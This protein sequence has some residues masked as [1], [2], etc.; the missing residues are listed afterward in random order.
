MQD[1]VA[2]EA[3]IIV[4]DVLQY[5]KGWKDL[6]LSLTENIQSLEV[7][8]N[9]DGSY[10]YFKNTEDFN[11]SKNGQ[12]VEVSKEAIPK[13]ISKEQQQ[14]WL[15]AGY[16]KVILIRTKQQP[17]SDKTLV[18]VDGVPQYGK[19]LDEV[20][21]ELRESPLYD[22]FSL[23]S[24]GAD[25][26]QAILRVL[27]AEGYDKVVRID[28][29]ASKKKGGKFD[30]AHLGRLLQVFPNPTQDW[31]NLQ[32]TI[33]EALPITVTVLDSQGQPLTTLADKTYPAGSHE[34][35]W[36]ASDQKPGVYFIQWTVGEQRVTRK[37]V[38]E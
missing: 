11:A 28:S 29:W 34:V 1:S 32:F 6:N 9:R 16:E 23:T 2:E 38:I 22:H 20:D 14:E 31:F 3:L 15:A 4:D 24:H 7:L 21:Q 36:D 12:G 27:R 5:G 17:T 8:S 35:G 13:T 18:V 33:G 30:P 37:L 26:S 19:T 25:S 10:R